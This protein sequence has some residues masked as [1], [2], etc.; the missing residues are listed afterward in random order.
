MH[1]IAWRL[2]ASET[3]GVASTPESVD[4]K[5]PYM[6]TWKKPMRGFCQMPKFEHHTSFR[7]RIV[8][9]GNYSTSRKCQ[10]G[11]VKRTLPV[12]HQEMWDCHW[13][14]GTV[15]EWRWRCP[16]RMSGS[17]SS[18]GE[19][20]RTS[21]QACDLFPRKH[22]ERW[23]HSPSFFYKSNSGSSAWLICICFQVGGKKDPK[24]YSEWAVL[25]HWGDITNHLPLHHWLSTD[26]SLIKSPEWKN[27]SN[28]A[29]SG[30]LCRSKHIKEKKN[31]VSQLL[32]KGV[33]GRSY[34]IFLFL[35]DMNQGGKKK[36]I[37]TV[38]R[39]VFFTRQKIF[40]GSSKA[41]EDKINELHCSIETRV[42]QTVKREKDASVH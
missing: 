41:F 38:I 37:L 11:D 27:L 35:K 8:N 42:S 18:S 2:F 32:V 13:R 34:H 28:Q 25:S 6:C 24:S 19:A 20:T 22:T 5:D 40:S 23:G 26:L 10:A 12:L 15:Q 39:I 1:G 31:R 33:G 9:S 21:P 17:I 29:N 30:T 16:R 36:K 7:E 3:R 4:R 14:R